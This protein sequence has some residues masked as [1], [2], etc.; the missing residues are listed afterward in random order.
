LRVF[1]GMVGQNV[2]SNLLV[3]NETNPVGKVTDMALTIADIL[4]FKDE[5]K[6]AGLIDFESMSLFDR[7]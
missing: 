4:G 6:A 7:I 1:G 2:P 5:V 3:G